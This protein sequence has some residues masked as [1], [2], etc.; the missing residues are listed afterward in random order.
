MFVRVA[1]RRESKIVSIECNKPT[2]D[3]KIDRCLNTIDL[4]VESI[5]FGMMCDSQGHA[6][7]TILISIGIV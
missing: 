2:G 6:T 4:V 7:R 3:G 5:V 1:S